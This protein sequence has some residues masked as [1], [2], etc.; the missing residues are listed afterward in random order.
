MIT[1]AS[2]RSVAR[3]PLAAAA[4]SDGSPLG[5]YLMRPELVLILRVTPMSGCSE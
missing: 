5:W 2:A 3:M 1:I 4:Q